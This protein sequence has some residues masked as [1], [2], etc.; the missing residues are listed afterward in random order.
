M[1]YPSTLPLAGS[2]DMG[3]SLYSS[4][5]LSFRVTYLEYYILD[6]TLLCAITNLLAGL[7]ISIHPSL[8]IF[9]RGHFF[10]LVPLT[11]NS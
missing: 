6:A 8:P 9:L 11:L 4:V 7:T 1:K 2:V 5:L 10:W 3:L